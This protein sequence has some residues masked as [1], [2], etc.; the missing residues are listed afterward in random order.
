MSPPNITKHRPSREETG[1]EV[2]P[3]SSH[4]LLCWA[5]EKVIAFS[6]VVYKLCP[7]AVLYLQ[8]GWYH[9]GFN[10]T[11]ISS[12]IAFPHHLCRYS[13]CFCRQ[14]TRDI[15]WRSGS[16]AQRLCSFESRFLIRQNYLFHILYLFLCRGNMSQQIGVTVPDSETLSS[17]KSKRF[18]VSK[19]QIVFP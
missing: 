12:F 17:E 19:L 11:W 2:A 6:K 8:S 18:T 5:K 1:D 4:F 14:K 3:F 10:S 16:S 13:V 7:K 15:R 9:W